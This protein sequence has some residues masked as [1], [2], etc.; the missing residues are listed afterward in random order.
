MIIYNEL[1]LQIQLG[2]NCNRVA[3]TCTMPNDSY[4]YC[5]NEMKRGNSDTNFRDE[6]GLGAVP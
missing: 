1:K 5:E 2:V 6:T 3:H 4:N